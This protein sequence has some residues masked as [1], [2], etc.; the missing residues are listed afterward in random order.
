MNAKINV[1]KEK[2]DILKDFYD[3]L[4]KSS[5]E[6]Q[7]YL[8]TNTLYIMSGVFGLTLSTLTKLFNQFLHSQKVGKYEKQ[9]IKIR[10]LQDHI[11]DFVIEK[12]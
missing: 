8:T 10:K 3:A 5:A 2:P 1:K 9:Q 6:L 4:D 7:L 12:V 11:Y